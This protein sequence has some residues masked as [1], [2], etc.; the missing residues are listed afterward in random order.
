MSTYQTDERVEPV[1]VI[2]YRHLRRAARRGWAVPEGAPAPSLA[3]LGRVRGPSRGDR[4]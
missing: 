1:R 2:T 3:D 4:T